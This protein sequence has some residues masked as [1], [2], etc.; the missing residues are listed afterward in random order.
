MGRA[1]KFKPGQAWGT[2]LTAAPRVSTRNAPAPGVP[3]TSQELIREHAK[4]S[5]RVC[6][7]IGS[8]KLEA[9]Q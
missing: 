7:S 3:R 2:N 6:A 4:A 9:E 1:P 5:A 8:P